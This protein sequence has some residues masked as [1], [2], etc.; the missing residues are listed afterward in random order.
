MSLATE[1]T[2]LVITPLSGVA[3]LTLTPWSGRDLTQTLDPITGAGTGGSAL[4]TWLRE[5]TNGELLD[6]SYPWFRKLESTITCKD[7]QTPCL[8]DVWKGQ[9]CVVDCIIE[10]SYVTGLGSPDRPEVS[11]SSRTEGGFT[12]Y[13]PQLT[14]RIT[15]IKNSLTEYHVDYSWQISLRE[16]APP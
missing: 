4:G 3:G 14:M 2:I 8:N 15:D 7:T 13:R 5:S 10:R 11:G 6:L 9:L 1:G 16:V 12:F